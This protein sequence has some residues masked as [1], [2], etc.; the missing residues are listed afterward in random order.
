[1]MLRWHGN[2]SFVESLYII[3]GGFGNGIALSAMFVALTTGI[4]HCEM[5]IGSSGLYLSSSVGMA[6]GISI[7]SAL[8]QSALGKQL[9][10][11]LEGFDR[12]QDVSAI[13]TSVYKQLL[14]NEPI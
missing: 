7:V 5:A 6:A 3:P 8:L 11:S 12:M 10:I 9:R 2:T 1:M 13:P 14:I 4:D